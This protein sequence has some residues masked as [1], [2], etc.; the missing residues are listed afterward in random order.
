MNNHFEVADGSQFGAANVADQ[1]RTN[2]SEAAAKYH[3]CGDGRVVF[4]PI[5]CRGGRFNL[6]D[7]EITGLTQKS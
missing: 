2:L 3:I 6:P 4:N 7:L 5:D 1:A